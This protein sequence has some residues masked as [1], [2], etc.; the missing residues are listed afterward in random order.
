MR[1][2]QH[3]KYAVASS[4]LKIAPFSHMPLLVLHC[5]MMSSV[6]RQSVKAVFQP[7]FQ[8]DLQEQQVEVFCNRSKSALSGSLCNLT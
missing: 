5:L 6:A 7:A 1:I 2:Y 8:V 4:R 3:C